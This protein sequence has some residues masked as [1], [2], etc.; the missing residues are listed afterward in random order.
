MISAI[1]INRTRIDAAQKFVVKLFI[2]FNASK[3]TAYEV[4]FSDCAHAIV[5]AIDITEAMQVPGIEL[6]LTAADVPND[7]PLDFLL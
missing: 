2:K 6:I 5:K 7:E 1:G 4:K 3:F